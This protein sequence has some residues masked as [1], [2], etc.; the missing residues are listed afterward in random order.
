MSS[1]R[2]TIIVSLALAMT[3]CAPISR[4]STRRPSS[5]T[6]YPRSTALIP[7]SIGTETMLFTKLLQLRR[8]L[9]LPW[10]Q[11]LCRPVE[12]LDVIGF[13]LEEDLQRE[14]DRMIITRKIIMTM[15]TIAREILSAETTTSTMIGSTGGTGIVS[16]GIGIAIVT[17]GIGIRQRA[18][19]TIGIEIPLGTDIRQGEIEGTHP[20]RGIRWRMT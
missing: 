10:R 14:E 17:S 5:V 1:S 19:E 18:V 11:S 2:S 8:L 6:S 16:S 20:G 15:S 12:L 3:S 9:R 7:R 13:H 4:R